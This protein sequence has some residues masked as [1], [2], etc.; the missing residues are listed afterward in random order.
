MSGYYIMGNNSASFIFASLFNPVAL[1]MAKTPKSFGHSECKR[2]NTGLLLKGTICFYGSEFFLLSV[3]PYQEGLSSREAS[4]TPQKSF[5]FV[6]MMEC[7][8]TF[9]VIVIFVSPDMTEIL[10]KRMSNLK[11]SIHPLNRKLLCIIHIL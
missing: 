4:R 9:T 7:L 10:L 1:R 5:P 2:V 6:K 3:D 11:S 8:Y